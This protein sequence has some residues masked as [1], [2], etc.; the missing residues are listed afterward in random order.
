[1]L[2]PPPAAARA[3]QV[4]G[5]VCARQIEQLLVFLDKLRAEHGRAVL[6]RLLALPGVDKVGIIGIA[7]PVHILRHAVR[8]RVGDLLPVPD[9]AVGH[10]A[11]HGAHGD[12]AD[13]G[14]HLVPL[15]EED[16]VH[17][18]IMA[19]HRRSRLAGHVG[20]A[21]DRG[22]LRRKLLDAPDDGER[23]VILRK[24][25]ADREHAGPGPHDLL[26]KLLHALP[27]LFPGIGDQR[28]QLLHGIDRVLPAHK[29]GKGLIVVCVFRVG[30]VG[31]EV[32][33]QASRIGDGVDL[34]RGLDA[35]QMRQA[36]HRVE[37]A[38]AHPR[39]VQAL[40][41]DRQRDRRARRKIVWRGQQDDVKPLFFAGVLVQFGTHRTLSSRI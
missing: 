24:D 21:E 29:P 16:V 14:K 9:H 20:A 40:P 31:E 15:A 3:L 17:A 19:Q 18:R 37:D 28:K 2:L 26:R 36:K 39:L 12:A 35:E 10:G 22:D 7:D 38:R 25:G 1:M 34:P 6:P 27:G 13:L 32:L 33:L 4:Q 23:A 5:V 41:E 30:H 11:G 8:D